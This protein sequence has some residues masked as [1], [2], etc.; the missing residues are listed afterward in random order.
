MNHKAHIVASIVTLLGVIS[1]A[2]A[3][4][5]TPQ[6]GGGQI[7]LANAPMKHADVTFDGVEINVHVDDSVGTPTLV[8]LD[9]PFEFEPEQ[10]WSVLDGRAYNFQYGWNPGGFISLPPTAWIWIEQVEATSGLEVYQRPPAQPSYERIFNT[11]GSVWRWPGSMTHN[12]YAIARPRQ[13]VF[14]ATYRVYVGD[15][16]TGEELVDSDE[17]PRYGADV[18][19]FRFDLD[20]IGDFDESGFLD[21]P[22]IDIL[23][24]HVGTGAYDAELDLNGDEVLSDLDRQFWITELVATLPGD[25]DLNGA[26]EFADFLS[27]SSSFGEIAGWADGDFD[28]D[29]QVQFPDFLLLSQNFGQT[30]QAIAT[31]PEG[32]GSLLFALLSSVSLFRRNGRT[33]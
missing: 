17:Q 16:V 9:D 15:D 23:G 31:V 22:D 2:D 5:V 1:P 24:E 14:E 33:T 20:L 27:L 21:A 26:V 11:D 7:G 19:T 6:M 12:V 25:A 30:A 3:Q 4:Y 10:P 18:V 29:K 28:G 32:A 8:P 13:D